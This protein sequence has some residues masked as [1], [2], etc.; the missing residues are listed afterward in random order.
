MESPSESP[1]SRPGAIHSLCYPGPVRPNLRPA[2]PAS[3]VPR[4]NRGLERVKLNAVL[5]LS[6][7]AWRAVRSTVNLCRLAGVDEHGQ[8]VTDISQTRS[9]I[10]TNTLY[11][12]STNNVTAFCYVNG[13]LMFVARKVPLADVHA[14]ID[15]RK[16]GASLNKSI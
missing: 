6:A 3:P 13:H 7:T 1:I 14:F 15:V 4:H 8:I 2:D 12:D 10:F 16:L 9:C 5:R 11:R